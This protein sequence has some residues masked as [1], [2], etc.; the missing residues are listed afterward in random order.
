MSAEV[1]TDAELADRVR[2]DRELFTVMHDRY[3]RDVHR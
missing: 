1:A 2:Q 3:Y